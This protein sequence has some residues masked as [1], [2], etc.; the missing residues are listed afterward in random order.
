MNK[1]NLTEEL[2]EFIEQ[3][4]SAFHVIE[5][6]KTE[7]RDEGYRELAEAVPW[8]LEPGGKYY[9]VRNGASL[10]AW[11]MPEREDI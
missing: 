1:R 5:N 2:L 9:V 7:L 11:Q 4:P 10:I 8:S 6:M 3:S